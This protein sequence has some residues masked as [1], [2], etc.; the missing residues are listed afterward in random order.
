MTAEI[1]ERD[2][3]RLSVETASSAEEGSRQLATTEYHRI[4]SADNMPSRDGISFFEA[5]REDP[6]AK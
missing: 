5:V 4:V 2:N 3:D 1:L 6:P